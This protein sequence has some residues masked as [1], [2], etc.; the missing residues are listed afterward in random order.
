MPVVPPASR[1]ALTLVSDPLIQASFLSVSRR[2]FHVF[3][4]VAIARLTPR[5]CI[6]DTLQI[7]VH[8]LPPTDEVP[9]HT[10]KRQPTAHQTHSP[11]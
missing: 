10:Q 6:D 1:A 4:P 5:V 3:P 11:Q 2:V 9:D 7:A 8:R